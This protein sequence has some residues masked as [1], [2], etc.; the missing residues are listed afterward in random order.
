MA[1]F[2]LVPEVSLIRV[3]LR[4]SGF[5]GYLFTG[6][7]A[8]TIVARALPQLLGF[9]E[10]SKGPAP[11]LLHV[12]PLYRLVGGGVECVY[13]YANCRGRRLVKCTGEPVPVFLDGDYHFYLGLHKSVINYAEAVSALAGAGGCFEFM[14]QRVCVEVSEVAYFDAVALGREVASE[15]LESGGVKVVFSSPT[16]LRD[17]LRPSGKYK[18]YSP[19]PINVFATPVY[20]ML[21]ARGSFTT[22]RF[23]RRLIRLHRLFNETYSLLGGVR[24]KWVYYSTKPEP[25]LVG[26]VNYRVNGEYAEYLAARGMDLEEWLGAVFAYTIALG[27]GAGRATG[28]GHVELKPAKKG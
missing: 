24:V 27:V 12:S 5:K 16:L 20:A 2:A 1:G 3:S 11:K 17:P 28:F 4:V 9:F 21:H 18:A 15:A 8:K 13:S 7:F 26:Y 22:A 14:G 23:R 10:P 25:A 6:K 19:T